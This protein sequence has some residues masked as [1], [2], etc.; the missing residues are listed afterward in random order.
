M[1]IENFKSGVDR[2]RPIYASAPGALWEGINGAL[3][4]GGDFDKRK[5]FPAKYSLPANTYG[6]ATVNGALY[7]FGSVVAPSM[8]SGVNYQ[9]LVHPTDSG[10]AMTQLISWD[11]FD[12]K[13]YAVAKYADGTV[14][15][16]YDATN[17]ADW[18]TGTAN[19]PDTSSVGALVKTHRKKIYAAQSS[20]MYF[21]GTNAPAGWDWSSPGGDAGAGYVNMAN[22]Q[23]GSETLTGIGVYQDKLAVFAR[24]VVQIW[25]VTDD[26]SANYP[27][28]IILETGTRSHKSVKGFGDFDVFYLSDT[29][30]RSLRARDQTNTAGIQDVGVPIDSLVR[31]YVNTLTETQIAAACAVVEPVD[32][33]FWLAVGQRIYVF[34]YFPSKKISAWTWYEPGFTVEEMVTL[35]DRVYLRSG[36]V[37]YLYGGDDNDEYGDDYDVVAQ[38]PF[39][40]GGKPG[41]YKQLKGM[42]IAAEGAWNVTALVDPRDESQTIDVGLLEGVTY[43][44]EN[45]ALPGHVTHIAPRLVHRGAGFASLSNLAIYWQGG[46]SE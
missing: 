28:Q 6:L 37:I 21:C 44:S 18:E 26:E 1:V 39:L 34:S 36:A 11:V 7:V 13:L 43:P 40:S 9:R 14:H 23:T 27:A 38:L 30:I 2:S 31:D 8:P 16:F 19:T 10:Q 15:H 25:Y 20:L 5:A 33:R 22:H 17:V 12:G 4:R 32:G 45:I 35:N 41:T 3:S 46:D 29:G 42:D 24:R